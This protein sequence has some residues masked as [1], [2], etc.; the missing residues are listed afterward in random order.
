MENQQQG[1]RSFIKKS[2]TA[3][4]L[5][6]LGLPSFGHI[7]NTQTLKVALI[8][9][10]WYGKM[11]L[12][13]LIQIAN[14]E[15]V[16]LCD[17]D[18]N[19]L[20]EA[21][22]LLKNRFSGHTPSLY[23]DYRD[24]LK[25][26]Q[27][28]I[29]VIGTPDHW[30]ALQAIAAMKSGSHI[31]LQKPI[32]VDVI[33][34]EAVVAAAKKYNKIVQVG[35]QRRSTPHLI[36]AKQRIIDT[37]VLGKISQIE[38]CSYYHMRYNENPPLQEIPSFFD[39]DLWTG[40]AP[41]RPF[42]GL[43][44]KR[45]WRS[46]MEYGNGIT[47]DMCVHMLDCVRWMLDLGWPL[48]ISATGGIFVQKEGKSNIADTQTA[49][50]EYEE[51]NIVWQHRTWGNPEDPEYPWA[52]KIF[53]ENGYLAGSP[54]QADFVPLDKDQEK[55]HWD[56]VYEKEAFPEDLDEKDIELHAVPATR[57]H[58]KNLVD[59]IKSNVDPV[60]NVMEGHIST[61]C[62]ILVNISME[63]GRPLSYDPKTMTIPS[64]SEASALLRR[65]YR[66]PWIHPEPDDI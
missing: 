56:A 22:T 58:F 66:K 36:D 1:R 13:R 33:E 15:V 17:V 2:A 49:I 26:H 20:A 64:D 47:G 38:I 57:K 31:Y 10:G 14:V 53:G 21:N 63:L 55:I 9:C 24:L 25:S 61:A 32:S 50:F 37:G 28:D 19:H 41:L 11:D 54:F 46:F 16:A 4:A 39:Y 44:H 27:L 18:Q 6:G 7:Q 45:K 60:A 35:L 29:T 52:F 30:H 8:G 34:G 40:P 12:W 65:P 3:L 42:D 48:K 59:A 43:P 5:M 62:C 23:K 51:L